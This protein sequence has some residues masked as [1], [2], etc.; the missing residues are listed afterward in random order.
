VR[1]DFSEIYAKVRLYLSVGRYEAAEKL[2]SNALDEHGSLA[3]LHNLLGLTFHKQSKFPDAIVQFTKALKINTTFVEAGLNLAATFCDLGRYDDAKAIFT[4]VV[5]ATPQNK[6][7]PDLIFGRLANH[8][9]QCGKLYE[10]SGLMTEAL[11]EYKRALSLFE[12][13]PDVRLALGRLLFRSGQFDKAV[14]EFQTVSTQFPDEHEAHLWSGIANWKLGN[15]DL[16]HRQWQTAVSLQGGNGV[17]ASYLR[18]S[19]DS[20]RPHEGSAT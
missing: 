13:M 12:R 18:F 8:H 10:Q 6:K 1:I 2:L 9:A 3:N 20:R 15:V 5:S 14:S 16:A 7:Q 4:E 11:S 19:Q 17:A